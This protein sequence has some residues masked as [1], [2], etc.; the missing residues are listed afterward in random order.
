[1]TFRTFGQGIGRRLIAV[2]LLIEVL[3]AGSKKNGNDNGSDNGNDN[4]NNGNEEDE[5]VLIVNERLEDALKTRRGREVLFA[6]RYDYH[7]D[8]HYK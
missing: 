7:Y 3:M 2:L 6:G 5:A 4:D 1:M 8:Y